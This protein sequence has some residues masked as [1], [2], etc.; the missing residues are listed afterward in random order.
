MLRFVKDGWLYILA[1][2]FLTLSIISLK[3]PSK[4]TSKIDMQRVDDGVRSEEVSDFLDM[5]FEPDRISLWA[6]I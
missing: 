2:M 4:L 3:K 6:V 5:L 1:Q